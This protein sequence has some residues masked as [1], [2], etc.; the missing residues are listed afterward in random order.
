MLET[1]PTRRLLICV[2]P[3]LLHPALGLAQT[4][5]PAFGLWNGFLRQTNVLECSTTSDDDVELRVTLHD[6]RNQQIGTG[7]VTVG[8][9]GTRHL[10]LNELADLTDAYGSFRV[11][12]RDGGA[13][14]DGTQ[15]FLAIY[16]FASAGSGELDYA[17]TLPLN[18]ILQGES[19]GMYRTALPE[20]EG[21][22]TAWLTI[23][24][25]GTTSFGSVLEI[26]SHR[27]V[28]TSRTALPPIEPGGRVD[29]PIT[30]DNSSDSP[31]G[32]YRILPTRSE[33]NYIAML[34]QYG[35]GQPSPS[36]AQ[37]LHPASGSCSRQ[38][39]FLSTMG[40]AENFVEV[41]NLGQSDET[42]R[43]TVYDAVG[44]TLR[45]IE[46]GLPPF[47]QTTV[48]VSALLGSE[49][50][51][52]A[53]LTCESPSARV[54]LQATAFG[55]HDGDIDWAYT[56]QSAV[57][58]S[59]AEGSLLFG[60]N[61]FLGASNWLRYL[62]RTTSSV[63]ATLNVADANA[64]EVSDLTLSLPVRA[65][66]D[67]P[68]HEFLGIDAIGSALLRGVSDGA[69]ITAE[70]LRVYYRTDGTLAAILPIAAQL[71]TDAGPEVTLEPFL[72]GLSAP[73]YMT[74]AGDG[75]GRLFIVERSGRVRV[76]KGGLLL[77]DPFIDLRGSV[78]LEGEQGLHSIAFHPNFD[79]NRR[80]FL[81]YNDTAGDTVLVEYLA[82][83]L[84]PD[85]IDSGSR[86]VI[87]SVD[88][89]HFFH[90]GGQLAFGPDGYLYIGLGDGGFADDPLGNGQ[91][92]G[93]LLGSIL[94]IDVDGAQPYVIPDTN[95]FRTTTG[96][97]G[98]I[99]AYGFRN[100][101]RFSFDRLDGRLFVGD[102]GQNRLEEIS[103]VDIGKNYGWGTMEGSLCHAP[104][105]G[106]DTTG[107]ELPIAEYTHQ[108]G[109][110]VVGGYVYR[111]EQFPTLQGLYFFGDYSSGR[112][113]AL[114][115]L[116]GGSWRRTEAFRANGSLFIA[117]FAE[118]ESG[119]LYVV[120]ILGKIWRVVSG[121]Q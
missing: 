66:H 90:N 68:L 3:L 65:T 74:H 107:L 88:Q 16:R 51:G 102:V 71:A 24:N 78:G 94:R 7:D 1:L 72:S 58:P 81:H 92:L 49:S 95:P 96:A 15:C 11:G 6:Q 62:N 54:L 120:D 45:T 36:F 47:A 73:V 63:A 55:Y 114:R 118:D 101:W 56:T 50:T 116:N 98:E 14:P 57:A 26:R 43:L 34:T 42:V 84:Q 83:A 85:V 77:D 25:P 113:W 9:L 86:R 111:G 38:T 119:E 109:N 91:N 59:S 97:A 108:E 46:R 121:E 89:P 19:A 20:Q 40:P 103:L 104:L 29:L 70:L 4:D 17:L 117:S 69:D 8:A 28:K 37:V 23:F 22:L 39:I 112:I 53:R 76:Y 10:I 18:R 21:A 60:M 87:L 79:E 106:C 100:P 48:S 13:L 93:T 115:E 61:T 64:G 82:D 5:G 2:A 12:S 110:A 30:H 80:V 67:I 27:G 32:L 105:A 35:P 44:N 99:F 31:A 41:A 33:Q 52:S 75:S